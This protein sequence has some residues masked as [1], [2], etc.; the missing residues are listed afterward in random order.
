MTS[1]ETT[2]KMFPL[3]SDGTLKCAASEIAVNWVFFTTTTKR[4]SFRNQLLPNEPGKY[5]LDGPNLI[6]NNM[7][8]HDVG[9]YHCELPDMTHIIIVKLLGTKVFM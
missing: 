1:A 9:E 2:T 5:T 3:G 6:V 4:I 7:T 8:V